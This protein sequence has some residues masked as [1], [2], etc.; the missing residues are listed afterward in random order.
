VTDVVQEPISDLAIVG[1]GA[2]GL[3]AAIQGASEGMRVVL[4]ER[5]ELGGRVRERTRVETVPGLPVGLSGAEFTERAV[6]MAARFGADLR[7]R[8]EI[9]GLEID[10]GVRRLRLADGSDLPALSVLIATGTA[11]PVV[12]APGIRAL[13]GAGVY[14]GIPRVLPEKLRG[15]DVF[16]TG[17]PT[18]ARA[19]AL[20]LSEHCRR[21][22]LLT[23]P[24]EILEAAGVERLEVLILRDGRSGRTLVRN[25]DALFILGM[26]RPRTAW[27]AGRPALDARGYVITGPAWPPL[28]GAGLAAPSLALETSVPGVFAAGGVRGARGC[29]AE[30]IGAEGMVA[31]RQAL[32]Y[33]NGRARGVVD[34]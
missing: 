10:G 18:A 27:L 19:G 13:T 20:R 2:T 24:M 21:A 11:G 22:A 1:G 7:T 16:V 12:P 34:E 30:G 9:V 8:A 23:A 14:F 3:A 15:R 28:A 29:C 25:A 33:L 5:G 6:S 31:A 17:E 4:L 26:D 32:H